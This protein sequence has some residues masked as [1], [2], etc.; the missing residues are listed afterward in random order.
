VRRTLFLFASMAL[1]VL[2]ACGAAVW[3]LGTGLAQVPQRP[4][5]ILILTDDL[6]AGSISQMSRLKSLMI[7]RGTTFDNAFVTYPT[8]CPSRTT[9]LRGQYSHNH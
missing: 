8:C 6:D 1:A 5:I 9:S 3:Q 7:E 4:N 2:L